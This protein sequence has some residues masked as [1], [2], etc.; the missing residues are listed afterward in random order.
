MKVFLACQSQDVGAFPPNVLFIVAQKGQKILVADIRE[1]NLVE[2][3]PACDNLWKKDRP[4][5]EESQNL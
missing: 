1:E 3:I 4:V 2:H 5:K